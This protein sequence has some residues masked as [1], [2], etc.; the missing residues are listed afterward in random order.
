MTDEELGV[1]SGV[2]IVGDDG[3]VDLV[4]QCLAERERQGC[5]AGTDGAAD[6]D[7]QGGCAGGAHKVAFSR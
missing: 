6:A 3:H 4:A 5:L 2:D 7:S 1:L